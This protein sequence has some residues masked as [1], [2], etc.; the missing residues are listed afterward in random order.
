[1]IFDRP[2]FGAGVM[3]I[4]Y[5]DA[6]GNPRKKM[7]RARDNGKD[8]DLGDAEGPIKAKHSKWCPTPAEHAKNKADRK[9]AKDEKKARVF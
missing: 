3:V 6:D 1:M 7:V 5:T 4:R 9:K 8:I 2:A